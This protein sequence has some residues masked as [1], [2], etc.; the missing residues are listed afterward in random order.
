MGTIKTCIECDEN[1]ALTDR[2]RCGQCEYLHRQVLASQRYRGEQAST[3]PDR[4]RRA[5]PR[6]APEAERDE[7]HVVEAGRPIE[8]RPASPIIEES[9]K[10]RQL[11]QSNAQLRNQVE[12]L[13]KELTDLSMRTEFIEE[14]QAQFIPPSVRARD[15][16]RSHREAVQVLLC[17]D[18]H[19]EE[20]VDKVKVNGLNEFNLDIAAE[21]INQLVSGFLWTHELHRQKFNIR[22]IVLWLGGDLISGH[23]HPELMSTT[24]LHPT[25]AVLWLME[26]IVAMV[27]ELFASI[28]VE[29]VIIFC[30]PG[31]HGRTTE[32]MRVATSAENSFEWLLYQ[33]LALHYK[34]E[35]RVDVYA[36]KASI[37]YVDLYDTTLRFMHGH[38]I[39]YGSGVG[40]ISIPLNKFIARA[41]AGRPADL[42][43]IGHWHSYTPGRR[44]VVNGSLI[45]Y[46]EYAASRGFEF[47][48]PQQA[49]FL[50][51]SQYG[52]CMQTP[53]WLER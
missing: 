14:M 8:S 53:I 20:N 50:V 21:R 27:N 5:G 33:F 12:Q 23:I 31:N 7:P 43:C 36:P 1:P 34:R 3:G 18:W 13:M 29:K 15:R 41:D 49:S 39:Q 44:A 9:M 17:S 10:L 28:D 52:V 6:T 45:G 16:N 30:T 22:D 24:E 35:P 40:G 42:T 2:R 51:D 4:L 11:R 37:I 47:E 25:E 38:E 26:R 19:V 48:R 46:N 32:K